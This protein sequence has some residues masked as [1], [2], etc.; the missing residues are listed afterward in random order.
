MALRTLGFA[1]V[2]GA[3]LVLA[4]FNPLY[5]ILTY[6]F[7][8]HNHP[9]YF[10]WG[11]QLP[12]L[13]WSFLIAIV[14][15]GS[16]IFNRHKLPKLSKIDLKPA[17][18]LIL[19]VLNA[20]FVSILFAVDQQKSLDKSVEWTKIVVNFF[21][22]IF[23]IRSY[24][25][26]RMMIWVILLCVANWGFISFEVG[27]NRDIGVIAPNATEENAI[28]AHVVAILPFFGVYFLQGKKWEKLFIILAVPFCLNIMILA[29]SRGA[30]LA[31]LVISA[32]VIFLTK[33][34]TRFAVIA[35]L[36]LGAVVFLQLT[37]EQFWKRQD[38]TL[39]HVQESRP[40]LRYFIWRGAVKMFKDHPFG[41][42]GGGFEKLSMQYIPETD[43]RRSQHNTFLAV[44]TDWGFMGFILYLIFL[45]HTFLITF[46][47]KKLTKRLPEFQKFNLEATAIQ[48][49]LIA[50]SVAGLTHS[51]QYAEVVYWLSAFAIMLKNIVITEIDQ[52]NQ[53]QEVDQENLELAKTGPMHS[54][55]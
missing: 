13:R 28:A 21:V 29:N 26:Y 50:I 1:A 39:T 44:L 23:I 25:D 40:E 20:Y 33:G 7:E 4:L 6:F 53:M 34:K 8:W 27:S 52:M 31:L 42:G 5:G 47:I 18:W 11:S 2:Y 12:D 9:P 16:L 32:A 24:K 54:P 36:I 19:I 49:A 35:A 3:G 41:V 14:T 38:S 22:M 45:I 46:K 37:N 48:L 30:F 10:W 15:L 51:R 55:A 43:I 17:I